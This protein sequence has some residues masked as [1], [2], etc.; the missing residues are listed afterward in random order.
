MRT[1]EQRGALLRV[2]G[3]W[4][5]IAAV[6]GSVIGVGIL[7]VPSALAADLRSPTLFVGIWFL[8]AAVAALGA[9]CVAELAVMLP[10]A[11]GPYVYIQRA[12]GN[13][14]ALRWAGW[15]GSYRWVQLLSSWLPSANTVSARSEIS[16]WLEGDQPFRHR[17]PFPDPCSGL[18]AGSGSQKFLSAAKA[19]AFVAVLL[20]CLI[21]GSG[22]PRG[23]HTV[24]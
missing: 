9:N 20:V 8:G 3:T 17:L 2:L 19:I 10:K 22:G 16:G 11:G 12:Y 24:Q 23:T 21:G 1:L 7:R 18:K 5:G 6:I 14:P 13:Y 15:I 4:F